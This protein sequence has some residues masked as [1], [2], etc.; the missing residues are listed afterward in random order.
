MAGVAAF[1]CCIAVC[2]ASAHAASDLRLI[3]AVKT[4]NA[5][6]AR[7]LARQ[8]FDVNARQPDGSTALHWAAHWDDVEIAELLLKCGANPN[9]KNDYG[10]MPLWM[11][12]ESGSIRMI[13]AL[14]NAGADANAALPSGESVLMRAARSGNVEVVEAL[15]A[16]HADVNAHERVKGQTTLMWAVS[17]GHASTVQTLITHGVDVNAR[18]AGGFTALMFAAREGRGE[19]AGLLMQHGAD[20]NAGAADGSTPLLVATVRGH[21]EL[22][23]LFLD[24]GAKPDGDARRAGY[25]PLHWAAGVFEGRLSYD[26]QDAAGEWASIAGIPARGGKIRLIAALI[27]DGADLEARVTKAPPRYG[28]SLFKENYLIGATPFYL[29]AQAADVE[30]MRVLL[31]YGADPLIKTDDGTTTLIAAS[32]L[33][34]VD[35]ET[36]IPESSN[37]AAVTLLV[38]LGVPVNAANKAGFTAIHAAAFAG[39]NTIIAY[40]HDHGA[41]VNDIAANG[42]SPLGIAEGNTLSGF[43]FARPGT[44]ALLR[45]LGAQSVGAVTLDGVTQKQREGAARGAAQRDTHR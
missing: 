8:G 28:F 11:A 25:T 31:E 22:A 30:V 21:V 40:L 32:G 44:A 7:A 43:Y 37:L 4:H 23:E 20:V 41:T 13:R 39:T 35:A 1:V 3:D 14:L 6:A 17:Q 27:A 34:A 10:L 15:I 18:T 33:T 5:T 38:R 16:A 12:A 42:Q 2:T 19:I 29:A 45:Q 9:A 26:Y 36:H 24:A